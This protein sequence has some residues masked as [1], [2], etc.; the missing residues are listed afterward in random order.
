MQKQRLDVYISSTSLDLAVHRA[1]VRDVV[2]KMGMYPVGMENFSPTLMS[3]IQA[4][5][6][7]IQEADIFVGIY[8][9]RYGYIPNNNSQF[10]TIDGTV[11][12]VDGQKSIPHMEYLWALER[13]IPILLFIMNQEHPVSAQH[14]D[15][16]ES[17]SKLDDFKRDI[18]SNH[19]VSFFRSPEDLSFKVT[20]ALATL[21][22]T[23]SSDNGEAGNSQ[24]NKRK[25][26]VFVEN[27]DNRVTEAVIQALKIIGFNHSDDPKYQVTNNDPRA[28]QIIPTFSTPPSTL[29]DYQCDVFVIMPFAETF[30]A[31]YTDALK[32]LCKEL[33]LTIKR[34]DDFFANHYIME[35]IWFAIYNCRIVIADCTGRNPN[36]FYELGIAHTLGKQVI[37]I[38]QDGKDVPFD[39]SGRRFIEYEASFSGP[40]K[41]QENLKAAIVRILNRLD[42]E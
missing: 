39:V 10:T 29:P 18:S 28:I 30:N 16:S 26:Q 33:N 4:C 14:L 37:P 17:L 31:V 40:K 36:V 22:D 1:A 27:F 25:E 3:P 23:A 2:L 7:T 8:G 20:S 24:I 15:N 41:L 42:N 34:G 21:R 38:T 35:E 13:G 5:Y 9:V 12:S 32:P 6:E 11:R 19:V